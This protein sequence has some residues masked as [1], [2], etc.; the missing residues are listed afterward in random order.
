M[1]NPIK[2]ELQTLLKGEHHGFIYSDAYVE[3]CS[4]WEFSLFWL[5]VIFIIFA[6]ILIVGIIGSVTSYQYKKKYDF[7]MADEQEDTE[8]PVT[9]HSKCWLHNRNRIR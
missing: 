6:V 2:L 5:L 1:A 4:N 3:E 7:A 8:L 9:H